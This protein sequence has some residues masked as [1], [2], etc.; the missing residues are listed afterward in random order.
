MLREGETEDGV[1]ANWNERPEQ[2]RRTASQPAKRPLGEVMRGCAADV[3]R[4]FVEGVPDRVLPT[5]APILYVA[6]A[7]MK[8][9]VATSPLSE[10]VLAAASTHTTLTVAD[11]PAALQRVLDTLYPPEEAAPC[12]SQTST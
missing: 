3:L 8:L 1:R 5:T 6:R 7:Q 11:Y 10:A 12:G 9:L 4:A 2:P